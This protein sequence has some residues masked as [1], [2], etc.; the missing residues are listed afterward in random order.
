[1]LL[2]LLAL[3]LIIRDCHWAANVLLLLII[4]NVQVAFEVNNPSTTTTD[5]VVHGRLAAG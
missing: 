2:G 5:A 3:G 1:V 4:T